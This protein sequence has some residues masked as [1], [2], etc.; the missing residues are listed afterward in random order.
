MHQ[1]S[2]LV[3][4]AQAPGV[5]GRYFHG[6]DFPGVDVA[7][8]PFAQPDT[9]KES[10]QSLLNTTLQSSLCVGVGTT[11]ITVILDN[12]A[13][14]HGF[15]SGSAQ[16]RRAW[17]EVIA[18]SGTNVIYQSGAV[19]AGTAVTASPDPDLWLLRDCMLDSKNEPVPMFWQAQSPSESY[20]LPGSMTFDP[21]DPHFYQT[22]VYQTFPRQTQ[23]TAQP[24]RVTMRVLVQPIGLDVIDDL[25]ASGDLHDPSVRENMPT[26]EVGTNPLL[27]WTPATASNGGVIN[28]VP[29]S[30][31]SNTSA[32]FVPQ[33]PAPEH[34]HCHP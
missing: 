5:S 30:C 31:V 33:V 28:N 20:Q 26:Y 34:V 13:A 25:T 16:D 27:T 3:P 23:L 9:Q 2:T 8:I 11:G 21:S 19:P 10:V 18:Y 32:S 6:H 29:Y 4:V 15:P 12:V 1:S 17:V 14:G 22:H 7:L 24:D